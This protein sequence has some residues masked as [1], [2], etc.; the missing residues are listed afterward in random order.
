MS[1]PGTVHEN[2]DSLEQ[3]E[4]DNRGDDDGIAPDVESVAMTRPG[5]HISLEGVDHGDEEEEVR[6]R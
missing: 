5:S 6:K 4:P 1:I 3:I 2:M